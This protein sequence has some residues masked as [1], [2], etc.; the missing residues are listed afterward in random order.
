MQL[1]IRH[2]SFAV[3]QFIELRRANNVAL[4]CADTWS[5]P[6]LM[7]LTADFVYC[8]LHGFEELYV[9]GSTMKLSTSGPVASLRG[10]GS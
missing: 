2:P 3:P 9:S 8:R 7:D 4:V 6:R 5:G 10:R 1:K